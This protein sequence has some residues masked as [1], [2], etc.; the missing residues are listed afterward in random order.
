MAQLLE[1]ELIIMPHHMGL[2][3]HS[4]VL[5]YGK[6]KILLTVLY[7]MTDCICHGFYITAK[8]EGRGWILKLG[9]SK[10]VPLGI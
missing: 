4:S 6:E 2:W 3:I 9:F 7:L 8:G 5:A 10:D 1:Y